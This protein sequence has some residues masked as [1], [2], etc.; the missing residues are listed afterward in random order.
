MAPIPALGDYLDGRFVVPAVATAEIDR[1]SPADLDDRVGVFPVSAAHVDAAVDAA[2]RAQPAWEATRLEERVARLVAFREALLK[3]EAALVA[4]LGREIGK[5]VWEARGEVQALAA[6][7][8]ITLAE[9]LAL[10]KGFELE[11]GRLA[12]RYRPHGV[13]AVLGPFNF[14]LHLAH[15]HVVP[16]LATG[17]TVVFKPSE[18]APATAQLYA[19]AAHE[20]GFPAGVFNLVQ[21]RGAQGAALSAHPGVDGVLFTG[22]YATG[23]Q[24]QKANVDRPGR[25]LALELGGKNTA[26]VLADAPLEKS[27]Y[28]V[29]YSALVTAGQRCTAV[30][31]VVV[32]K[33]IAELFVAELSARCEMF[34]V[35]APTAPGVFYGPLS[36]EAGFEKFQAAQMTADRE[37]QVRVRPSRGVH[38]VP[39]GYYVR[40]SIHLVTRP[41]PASRYE[42][43]EIFGP[44]LAVYVAD[45]LEHACALADATPFGLAA[46]VFTQDEARFEACAARLRVGCLAWNAPTV[47]SSSR[48]P[49]GGLKNS[50]NHR[51]AALFST[52]YCTY[53]VAVTRGPQAFD[54]AK[55]AP[56]VRWQ[57]IGS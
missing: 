41:N 27:L 46:G 57:A 18:A 32:E 7:I 15:G 13:L 51:P 5:P 9:G 38:G 44:D 22:S 16:A 31:R 53:P 34:A 55:V 47:G 42:H 43:E 26:V 49:F 35:G 30:S 8:D 14:P 28:D 4:C 21:G 48:L 12:T 45:D 23:V 24:I 20:A 40:P 33:P 1:R 2:R 17:N 19:E 29:L 39:R 25:M 11:D 56:G 52:L 37:G 50:G 54:A 10:V 6:K 36:T 3:R